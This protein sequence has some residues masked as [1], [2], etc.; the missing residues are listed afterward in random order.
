M[1]RL[2][3]LVLGASGMLG[4]MVFRVFSSNTRFETYGTVRSATAR[5]FFAEGQRDNVLFGIDVL[6]IDSL[7]T[8]MTTVKPDVV[9][10]CIGLV[11]QLTESND[12]LSAL[13]INAM[14]PHR[15]SRLS[16]A[17][18]ARLVHISTDCVFSGDRG[19]YC[20]DDISDARDLYGKSKFIGEL[21]D[22]EHAITLRT[23]IIGHELNSSNG[24]VEWFLSQQEPVQGFR[25]AVFSG[26]PTVELVRVI[27]DYVIPNS[28][29]YGLYH[30]SSKPICKYDLLRL[31]ST[32]YDK[33]I[34]IVPDDSLV[35]DRSLDSC[36]FTQATGYMAPEWPNLVKAMYESRKGYSLNVQR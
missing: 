11:K 28:R 15:L 23:S 31:V 24:L 2:K 36:R 7:L 32:Q 6:D 30:V 34:E 35:I 16:G 21:H 10:N 33:K 18:G 27:A 8:A 3:V 19:L 13:P 9:V 4:S 20:E 12:P 5:K 22:D 29:L 25:K 17:I 26:L 1:S 14:L